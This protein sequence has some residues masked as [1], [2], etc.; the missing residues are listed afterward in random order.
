MMAFLLGKDFHL[1]GSLVHASS[2]ECLSKL[3]DLFFTLFLS[4]SKVLCHFPNV[5]V[6]LAVERS[7]ESCMDS[8]LIAQ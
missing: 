5:G 2:P 4:N 8:L 6:I 3:V 1:I 7:V